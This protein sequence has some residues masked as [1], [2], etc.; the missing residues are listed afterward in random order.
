MSRRECYFLDKCLL[1]PAADIPMHSLWAANPTFSTR[2]LGLSEVPIIRG[3]RSKGLH[4]MRVPARWPAVVILGGCCGGEDKLELAHQGREVNIEHLYRRQ[5]VDK[6][7]DT[8]QTTS[9]DER[10]DV[11]RSVSHPGWEGPPLK[12]QRKYSG[13][14]APEQSN[15]VCSAVLPKSDK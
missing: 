14:G 7:I 2:G 8:G 3:F 10:P 1:P 12:I 9:A 6:Q 13:G 5:F 15:W 4:Y 11:V